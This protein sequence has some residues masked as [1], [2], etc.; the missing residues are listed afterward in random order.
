MNRAL[1]VRLGSLG[2]IVHAMPVAAALRTAFPAARIDWVTHP[3]YVSLVSL[4]RGVDTVI[5]VDTRVWHTGR[6]GNVVEGLGLLRQAGYDVALDLQGLVKS[7]V[8]ARAAG[9]RRTLGFTRAHLREPAARFFYDESVDPGEVAH[10]IHKNLAFCAAVGADSR[11]VQFPLTTPAS[12]VA[13]QLASELRG[14]PYVLLNPGAAWPNKRWPAARFGALAS[15]L[16]E[17]QGMASV[18]LWGPDEQALAE[19]V[20]QASDGAARLAPPTSI[21][22]MV[23][24]AAGARM[25]VSG[26]TGP[27]HLAAAV[28]TPVVALFGPTRC[29]RN[30]PWDARDLTVA[31]TDVCECLYERRC[32]RARPC[33]GEIDV[34][35]VLAAVT[36]RLDGRV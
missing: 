9:A 3:A 2:D 32:R 10:V 18:V 26:D 14:Q 24:V 12:A 6:R 35:E 20:V 16:R 31:R 27:L 19:A 33:I 28:G 15:R 4:V 30:G 23:A 36:R 21:P 5:P 7:A 17:Q 8:L 34:N 22:D 29:E 11:T 1:L 25:M 13:A